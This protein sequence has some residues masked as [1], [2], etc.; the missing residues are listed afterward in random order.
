MSTLLCARAASAQ[1]PAAG[2]GES[3]RSA[4]RSSPLRFS[5][6]LPA[7][8]GRTRLRQF[9]CPAQ[10]VLKRLPP[11]RGEPPARFVCTRQSVQEKVLPGQGVLLRNSRAQHSLC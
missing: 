4:E 7:R 8:Q 6:K 1:L 10:P 5:E 9:V 3:P 11:V 2:R